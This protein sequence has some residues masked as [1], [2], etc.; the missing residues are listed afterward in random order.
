MRFGNHE[1]LAQPVR[2]IADQRLDG[3]LLG[4]E[5]R[6]AQTEEAN[7][8]VSQATA[9]DERPE[10]AVVRDQDAAISV[11]GREYLDVGCRWPGRVN[12]IGDIVT[13]GSGTHPAEHRRSHRAGSARLRRWPLSMDR[14]SPP[15]TDF[16]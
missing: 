1:E 13:R 14:Y 2:I 12:G 15:T 11:S 8:G 16:A 5:R 4:K 6:G 7:A 3:R 9:Q 10:I